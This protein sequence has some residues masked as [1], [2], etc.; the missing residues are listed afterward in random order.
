MKRQVVVTDTVPKAIGPY[1]QGVKAGGFLFLSGAIALDP[2]SGEMCQGGI[3]AETEL[4]M[5]NIG[6]LLQAAGLGYG[7]VVKTV[8][9][10][11]NIATAITN[12]E[13][14]ISSASI[15]STMDKRGENLFEVDVTDL[16]HL[17][18]VFASINKVRGVLKVER[19]R[20]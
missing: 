14:N 11:A 6:A 12:S 15:Q 16:D 5:K 9:Y 3:S 8:I 10:L 2:V 17:K 20:N 7:D 18:R 4:V 13:A 19:L 1:S